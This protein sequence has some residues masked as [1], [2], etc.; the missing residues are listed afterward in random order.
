MLLSYFSGKY[1]SWHSPPALSHRDCIQVGIPISKSGLWS[2]CREMGS[3]MREC[4][5]NIKRSAHET[6]SYKWSSSFVR[7]GEYFSSSSQLWILVWV[8]TR[9]GL[10]S[11]LP[12]LS[13]TLYLAWSTSLPSSCLSLPSIL[14]Y[15]LM[16]S[17]GACN[18]RENRR[19]GLMARSTC[20][21]E[22]KRERER[23]RVNA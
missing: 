20:E 21:R 13:K 8:A 2:L 23:R 12:I 19:G 14:S 10:I 11:S 22:R 18:S 4:G 5:Y 7:I 3:V 17:G 9:P 6:Y 16:N 1:Q 15:T